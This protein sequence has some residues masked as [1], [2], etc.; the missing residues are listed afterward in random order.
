[1]NDQPGFI[2]LIYVLKANGIIITIDGFTFT[3]P[4]SGLFKLAK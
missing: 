2:S 4:L 1:L 3:G